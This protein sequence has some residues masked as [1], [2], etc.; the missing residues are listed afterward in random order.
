MTEGEKEKL[1]LTANWLNGVAIAWF[2]IMIVGVL[3]RMSQDKDF[4]PAN[5]YFL[6]MSIPSVAF[7]IAARNCVGRLDS[8]K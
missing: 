8:I 2:A 7:H 4:D 6:V 1:K 5:Y 3:V